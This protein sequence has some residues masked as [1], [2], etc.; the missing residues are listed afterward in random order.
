MKT[1]TTLLLLA[2]SASA[3]NDWISLFDGKTFKGWVDPRALSPAG[4]AWTIDDGCIKAVAKARVREDL[5]TVEKFRDFELEFEWKIAKAGNSGVKYRIQDHFFLLPRNQGEPFEPSVER[6]LKGKRLPR[7]EGE[8]YVIGFE[9]QVAGQSNEDAMS[10]RRHS[11]GALY[12][13]AAPSRNVTRPEGEFNTARIVLRGNRVE[14][15]LNGVKVVDAPLDDSVAIASIHKRWAPAPSVE[16]L[17]A[18]QPRKACP[19]S[20]QNHNDEAW[21]RNIRVRKL[22]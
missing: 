13:I 4:D 11:A 20:L 6:T 10:D 9:Y 14:H 17:L 2:A 16:R 1:I 7:Q 18:K 21:F 22:N 5:F 8:D 19:I 15:W 3:A 12:G